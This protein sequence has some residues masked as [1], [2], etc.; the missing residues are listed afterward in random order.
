VA[1]RRGILLLLLT[2][3]ILML[4]GCGGG[5]TANVQNPPPP[6]VQSIAI[7]FQA[8]PAG[9]IPINTTTSLT[10]MVN[11]DPSNAGVD[12]SISCQ[13]NGSCGSL[14]AVHTGSGQATTYTP[15]PT[16]PGN[17]LMVTIVAFATADH[18]KNVV[19]PV[20]LTA[21]G[22]SLKGSYVLQV[23][24]MDTTL[25]PYQFAGVVVLDGNGGIVSG[26]QT[27]NFTD[28]STSVLSTVSDNITGGSYFV[29]ADGRGTIT[30]NTS[31]PNVGS[32]GTESFS[33]VTLSGSQALIAQLD[34]AE[35]GNGTMD[36]QTSSATP[37]G[38][39]AFV[40]SGTDVAS[41]SPTAF[42][43]VLNIDSPNNISGKGS[44]SDQNLA[45]TLTSN[46]KI[47]GTVSNPDSLGA[48][49][50]N[51]T[52]V[53]A[54]APIQFTGY[55][56]DATHIK[57]IESDNIGGGGFGSTAGIAIG[58][59]SATGTFTT[60]AAFSGTYVFGI[61]GD[62]LSIGLPSTLTSVGVFTADGTGLLNSGFTDTFLQ[63]SSVQ[64]TSGSKISAT[65]TGT[66]SVDARGNGRVH[67][68]F[69]SLVPRP[70]PNFRPVLIFYLTGNGNPP[71]VL[72]DSDA[73]RNYPSVGVGLAYPQSAAALTF[74]GDY[75]FS[76]TQQNG[77]E[78]DGT[79]Q[80]TADPATGTLSGV[81]D[82][83]SAFSLSLD[84]PFAGAF[85]APGSNGR[86]AGT[87]LAPAIPVEYYAIDVTHGFFVETDLADPVAP[88]G[89]VSLGYYAARTP[90]CSGCP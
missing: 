62:D 53:F 23:Q 37:T 10:A 76:V 61:L 79:G 46:K 57:L 16:L 82:F 52:A 55:I 20:A 56:V 9:S 70:K 1:I 21:F 68:V 38:G 90:V 71:L 78:S 7:T 47:S 13:G 17:S 29:G 4:I 43:G 80:L 66:Y 60:S 54:S 51:L 40:V 75:G 3:M 30:I 31:N 5:S 64:N 89:Q 18:T 14:S 72:D 25:T 39:Y 35:S 50:F 84:N 19:A 65:M 67:A 87:L 88:S 48:V 41:F 49:T 85:A 34:S 86:F 2:S 11:N 44:L 6:P 27:V 33:L 42:G 12:W 73:T 22:S 36:L 74:S 59:G 32:N 45:G 8:P 28:P 83:N 24:G 77:N 15:P 81:A 69:N 26:E 63:G 58:Q